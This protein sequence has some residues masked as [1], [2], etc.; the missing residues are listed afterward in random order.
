MH[1]RLR[2]LDIM[3]LHGNTVRERPRNQMISRILKNEYSAAA[4]I[5]KFKF[6]RIISPAFMTIGQ[7]FHV[8]NVCKNVKN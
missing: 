2:N 5:S 3:K 1:C 7:L 8:N 6:R 4:A